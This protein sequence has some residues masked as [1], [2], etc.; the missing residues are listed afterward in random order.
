VVEDSHDESRSMDFIRLDTGRP[1]IQT[2]AYLSPPI[3]GPGV[4][5]FP[6]NLA[7][8]SFVGVRGVWAK[9]DTAGAFIALAT[10]KESI[11]VNME[12]VICTPS[13]DIYEDGEWR[14]AIT[15][16]YLPELADIE[17]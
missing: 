10:L 12:Y 11:V 7:I 1:S 4:C 8:A 16:D 15:V 5:V 2:A 6:H 3:Q 14:L 9:I 13:S 17:A